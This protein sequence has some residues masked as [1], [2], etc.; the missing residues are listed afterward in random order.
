MIV[1]RVDFNCSDFSAL[2]DVHFE[3][4]Y[5]EISLNVWPSPRFAV[6][7]RQG[8]DEVEDVAVRV[9]DFVDID[10]LECVHRTVANANGTNE[11]FAYA[12][13]EHA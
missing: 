3:R 5:R 11:R 8:S 4:T 6:M 7:F 13:V 9:P 2:L 1:A 12:F 10:G